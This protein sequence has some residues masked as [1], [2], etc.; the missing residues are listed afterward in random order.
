MFS[1]PIQNALHGQG[2]VGVI[3]QDGRGAPM[4]PVSVVWEY[5]AVRPQGQGPLLVHSDGSF[6]STFQFVQVFRKSVT[7]TGQ[8]AKDFS[9]HSFR[10]GAATEAARR[11]LSPD[12]VRCIGRWESDHY[13][14]YVRPHLL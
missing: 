10:I 4:C 8:G 1:T 11:G 14:I 13:R 2:C 3:K 5:L 7:L 9:S 6:L 12:A